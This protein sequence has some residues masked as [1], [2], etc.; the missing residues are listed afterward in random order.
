[1]ETVT[2]P[3]EQ[4]DTVLCAALDVGEHILKSGGEIHRVEDTIERICTAYGAQHVEVFTI[5]SLI[6]AS[7][8]MRDGVRSQQMRRIY[9]TKNNMY[10]VEALNE[11]SRE[12]C[13]GALP[14]SKLRARIVEAKSR[15]PYPFWLVCLGA[16]CAA[17]GFVFFFGGNLLDS[18]C[19]AAAGCAVTIFQRYAP[20]F[21]NRMIVMVL[22]SLLAG[23]VGLGLTRLGL[24]QHPDKIMIG[25][26]MILVPGVALNNA[27]RDMMGGDVISGALQLIQSVLLAVM[28]AF[29]FAIAIYIM[30]GAV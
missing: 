5:P 13:T 27:V 15:R 22:A 7:V 19:A 9:E 6:V 17:A 10:M 29:G 14:L 26:I 25:T 8:Q 18:L 21:V 3:V 1:M 24:G 4:A 28:I 16:M 11:I 23:L 30:G 2:L 12:L 20:R